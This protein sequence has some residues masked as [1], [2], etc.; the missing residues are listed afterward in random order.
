LTTSLA[1][2]APKFQQGQKEQ[3]DGRVSNDRS[4]GFGR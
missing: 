4:K 3:S 2:T 1:I